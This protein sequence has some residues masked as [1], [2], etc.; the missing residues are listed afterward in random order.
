MSEQTSLNFKNVFVKKTLRKAY[1]GSLNI[2]KLKMWNEEQNL[3]IDK[4]KEAYRKC[5]QIR[6][7]MY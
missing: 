4:K 3:L 7:P 2:R 6:R 5:L 1:E